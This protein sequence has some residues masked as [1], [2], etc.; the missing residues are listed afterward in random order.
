MSIPAAPVSWNISKRSAHPTHARAKPATI[1]P[2]V[3]NTR[4]GGKSRWGSET[5]CSA[6]ALVSASVGK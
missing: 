6:S 5:W 2:M 1:H 3:P 4:T